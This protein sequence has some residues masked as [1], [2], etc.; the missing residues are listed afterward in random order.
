M[1]RL[2]PASCWHRPNSLEDEFLV[3]KSLASIPGI[4]TA[5]GYRRI[6]EWEVLSMDALPPL[7]GNDPTFGPGQE[8]FT[9]FLTVA[10]TV[11]A[12]NKRGCSHGDLHRENIGR[13]IENGMSVFDFD[14]AQRA[15][16]LRCML[17]DFLGFTAD[18]AGAKVSLFDRARTVPG[19]GLLPRAIGAV[20]RALLGAVFAVT[21]KSA[22]SNQASALTARAALRN[23]ASLE[24]LARAWA[25]AA[26]SNASAPG[27]DIAYYSVDVSG[28][29]FPGERPW[30][31]RWHQVRKGVD[32][33]GKRFLELGCNM[34]LLSIHAKLSGAES[35]L[36]LDRDAD[37]LQAARLAAQAF[38]AVVE[39]NQAD[40]NAM[41]QLEAQLGEPGARFDIVS[42]LS[43]MYWVK[44]KARM[45][46][47]LSRFSELLYEGHESESEAVQLLRN[48]GFTNV[49]RLGTTERN[50]PVFLACHNS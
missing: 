49:K 40:L 12:I 31:H 42:A 10:R 44:D 48:A 37:I 13:N 34:G 41:D 32:F 21:G 11:L 43:V 25:I 16:P 23:D 15:H 14:Q 17:R 3:L 7:P 28:M 2:T 18:R 39:F 33:S 19:L 35:C 8:T 6:G 24:T 29:N 26:R 38:G 5:L 50:R 22:N 30:L 27:V 4:P 36:A 46:R 1:R 47:F 45:W 20:R 9:D